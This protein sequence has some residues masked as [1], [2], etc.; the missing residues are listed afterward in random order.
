M[1]LQKQS[2]RSSGSIVKNW[3]K[4][5]KFEFAVQDGLDGNID[6]EGNKLREEIKG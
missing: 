5:C 4:N 2:S 6:V 1:T 3:K